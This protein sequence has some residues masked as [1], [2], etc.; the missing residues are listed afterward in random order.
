MKLALESWTTTKLASRISATEIGGLKATKL[1]LS[2]SVSCIVSMATFTSQ[3]PNNIGGTWIPSSRR[4]KRKHT[5]LS[6]DY[7]VAG[8]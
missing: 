3:L 6:L 2:I 1:Q 8:H 4:T 5:S 7:M